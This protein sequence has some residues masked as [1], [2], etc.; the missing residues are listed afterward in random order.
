MPH[1]LELL[2]V[3]RRSR[4]CTRTRILQA[5][6][7][8]GEI[9]LCAGR[10]RQVPE[11]VQADREGDLR[12]PAQ[13]RVQAEQIY[14]RKRAGSRLGDHQDAEQDRQTAAWSQQ[15]F[16]RNDPAQAD[17]RNDLQECVRIAHPLTIYTS[18]KATA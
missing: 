10:P 18:A 5:A 9:V 4:V 6:H 1:G 12:D 11:L 14:Q 16:G 7:P 15:P 2:Q 8:D 13:D 17:R 3:V